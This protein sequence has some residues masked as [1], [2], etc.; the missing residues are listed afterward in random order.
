VTRHII[1]DSSTYC[2]FAE[3]AVLP[4]H[5]FVVVGVCKIKLTIWCAN[6]AC[7]SVSND[8]AYCR[9]NQAEKLQNVDINGESKYSQMS[10]TKAF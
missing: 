5:V 3:A 4:P 7:F 6:V 2:L 8:S 10:N 1:F 9:L